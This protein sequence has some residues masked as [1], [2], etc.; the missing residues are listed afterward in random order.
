MDNPAFDA[1]LKQQLTEMIVQNFNHPSICFWGLYNEI[2]AGT[3]KIVATL[4]NLAHEL[5][6]SRLTTCAVYLDASTEYI[7]DLMC[8]NKYFG[9]YYGKKDD[10][11]PFYDQWHAANPQVCMGLSEYGAGGSPVQHVGQY[12]EEA[13]TIMDSMG[14]NHPMERQTAIHRTQWPVVAQRDYIWASYVWNMFDFGASGRFEGD[15]PNQNDKGLVTRD[16][17]VRKDA[18]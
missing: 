3:D 6:P 18:F 10:L 15:S 8:F 17:Q 13:F 12:D 16:R 2:Q 11:A 7:P 14:K 9:W 1:N 5:D 4:N